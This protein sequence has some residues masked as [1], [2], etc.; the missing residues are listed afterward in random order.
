MSV[1]QAIAVINEEPV[2]GVCPCRSRPFGGGLTTIIPDA[3]RS[4]PPFTTVRW[5]GSPTN[6]VP[7][8]GYLYFGAGDTT[9]P[10]KENA[11]FAAK[12]IPHAQLDVLPDQVNHDIFKRDSIMID[13]I[14]HL[15]QEF[16]FVGEATLRL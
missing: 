3:E 4:D 14:P 5:I 15:V 9:T 10:P 12:Y 1:M 13:P 7:L 2:A 16:V 6:G 11:E 8:R